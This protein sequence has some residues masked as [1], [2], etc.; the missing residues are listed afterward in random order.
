FNVPTET[1]DALNSLDDDLRFVMITS[2]TKV[3]KLP[4]GGVTKIAVI[5]SPHSKCERCWHYRADV[6]ADGEH[7]SICTRCVSN[8]FANGEARH[9]A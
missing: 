8:L 4:A 1:F 2:S 5:A 6:G 7:P 9:F 3:Y